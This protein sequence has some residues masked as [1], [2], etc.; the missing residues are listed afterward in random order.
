MQC[1]LQT[2]IFYRSPSVPI[3]NSGVAMR[4]FAVEQ[5][6]IWIIVLTQFVFVVRAM[7]IENV[8]NGLDWLIKL[9]IFDSTMWLAAYCS[10]FFPK[11][12]ILRCIQDCIGLPYKLGRIRCWRPQGLKS[13]MNEA[14]GM[15]TTENS[16]L[17]FHFASKEMLRLDKGG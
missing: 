1:A 12:W 2:M 13:C 15:T 5:T 10:S 11:F 9:E 8:K 14:C 6:W 17:S 4:G 7:F 16:F 3:Y